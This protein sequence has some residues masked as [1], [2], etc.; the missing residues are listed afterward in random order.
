M[1]G[2][3]DK[4][5]SKDDDDDGGGE[6]GGG[7]DASDGNSKMLRMLMM[8]NGKGGMRVNIES[9]ISVG[10]TKPRFSYATIYYTASTIMCDSHL[11]H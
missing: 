1:W 10:V 3:E 5:D 2:S 11:A 9:K 6:G 8:R 4:A 7:Y